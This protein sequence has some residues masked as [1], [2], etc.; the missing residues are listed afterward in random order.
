VR[1]SLRFLAL[2]VV[3]WIG[4]RWA[5][6]GSLPGLSLLEPARS[7]AKPAPA[8]V[9]TEFP[10]VAPL[11]AA[12]AEPTAVD[13][14]TPGSLVASASVRPAAVPVYYYGVGSVRVPLPP[15]RPAREVRLTPLMPPPERALSPDYPPITDF[16][17]SR[18]ASLAWP[19]Q[20]SAIV[21]PGQS[22]PVPP[23]KKLDRLQLTMWAFLRSPQAM[24]PVPRSLATNGMLGGS[25]AGARLFYNINRR[26]AAV[27]RFSSE[28]GRR[29]G[30]AALGVRVHPLVS[31]PVWIT[32]ERRQAIGKYGNGRSAWAL[33]AEGGVYERPLGGGFLLDGYA[34]A[35]VVGARRRDLFA[36][37][38]VTVTRPLYKQF[39]AGIG[40][41]GGAQPGLYR[42]DAGPRVTM[43]VRRNVRVHFDYRQRVAGN[44]RP[45]SGPA[46]T[47]AG[48]F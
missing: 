41:W 36:D 8:I 25:Q 22:L 13:S 40:V 15:A 5:M 46:V 39:S 9:A 35:G 2:V 18:L 44:A 10:A 16:P 48:D 37:G 23:G 19:Q 27:M 45:D 30:E 3:G 28:V 32:A 26:I 21:V 29:G 14:S 12:P 7:E 47:L 42:I 4:V 31:V 11:E 33:F 34:Q 43:Q 24:T 17:M 6:V 38:A 20:S 1:P